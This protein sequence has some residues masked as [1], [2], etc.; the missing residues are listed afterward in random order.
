M[1]VGNI[2][3][4]LLLTSTVAA[5]LALVTFRRWPVVSQAALVLGL[6]ALLVLSWI[7][8]FGGMS[9]DRIV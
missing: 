4:Y 8:V 2:I 7:Y 1:G 3:G 9:P 6:I 5:V